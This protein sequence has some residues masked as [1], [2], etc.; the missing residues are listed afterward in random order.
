MS[1]FAILLGGDCR[2]TGR[3]AAQ[4]AGA[5]IIAADSGIVHAAAL[6]LAPELWIGDF[7][8]IDPDG[9]PRWAGVPRMEFPRDKD[10]SDGEIA[11]REA[12][13][14]GAGRLVLVGAFGGPRS[15]HAV[16]HL[17]AALRL[18]KRGVPVLLTS[19]V[20]EGLAILP[21]SMQPSL[22]VGSLFSVLA[23]SD[24]K[25]LTITGARWPLRE[26]SV[27]FGSSLTLSNIAGEDLRI[28]LRSGRAMLVARPAGAE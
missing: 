16:L 25:G 28:T 9:D 10:E 23:F 1:L 15:D 22:P 26:R 18:A 4:I 2:P 13:R 20:E 8:S 7:D 27:P 17:T 14:R 11:A 6:G 24:L 3:L 5:R 21:G 19:G 12:I